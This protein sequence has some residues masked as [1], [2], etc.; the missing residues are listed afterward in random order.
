MLDRL[1]I[2]ESI[3]DLENS[4]PSYETC[5]NL[6]ALCI[7]QDRMNRC[8]GIGAGPGT[9]SE[10]MSAVQ[11]KPV[12]AVMAVVDDL[13]HTVRMLSPKTYQ[14]AIDSIKAIEAG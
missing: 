3:L 14:A 5:K 10:F 7:I 12:N 11:G 1:I 13:M 6:A 4:K 8:S 9:L 2:E